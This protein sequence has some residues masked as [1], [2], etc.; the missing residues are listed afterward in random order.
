LNTHPIRTEIGRARIRVTH[1]YDVAGADVMTTIHRVPLGRGKF[2]NIDVG[3]G[4]HVGENR[5]V[6]HLDGR[7][8]L[9]LVMLCGLSLTL[10]IVARLWSE[11]ARPSPRDDVCGHAKRR[12]VPGELIEQ[13]QWPVA[14]GTELRQAAHLG[15]QV[16]AMEL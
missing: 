13:E 8:E 4:K 14:L 16:G 15:L 2:L 10:A 9:D 11:Q 7:Y 6:F 12:I 5:A 1:H 3:T